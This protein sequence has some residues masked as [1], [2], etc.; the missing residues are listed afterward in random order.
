MRGINKAGMGHAGL[1]LGGLGAGLMVGAGAGMRMG[2]RRYQRVVPSAPVAPVVATRSVSARE[3][4]IE[5]FPCLET[6]TGERVALSGEEA[7]RAAVGGYV[8]AVDVYYLSD[9]GRDQRR[10]TRLSSLTCPKEV[11]SW[12]DVERVEVL[13]ED[14]GQVDFLLDD[15]IVVG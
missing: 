13:L 11:Q 3:R 6:G 15:G 9:R 8:Y 5:I 2:G 10:L 1:M 12:T 7:R 4:I 14:G